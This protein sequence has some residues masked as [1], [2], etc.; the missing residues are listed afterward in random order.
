MEEDGRGI[1]LAIKFDM[2]NT[3]L[4]EE[5]GDTIGLDLH[6]L[7]PLTGL[8]NASAIL[9]VISQGKVPHQRSH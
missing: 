3:P 2:K 4:W 8:F 5:M 9:S 7:C 6:Q 1:S